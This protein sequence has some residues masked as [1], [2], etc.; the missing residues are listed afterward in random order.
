MFHFPVQ[1]TT[2]KG[3]VYFDSCLGAAHPKA[4]QNQS[5]TQKKYCNFYLSWLKFGVCKIRV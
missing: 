1:C 3:V 5:E 2:L 4:D